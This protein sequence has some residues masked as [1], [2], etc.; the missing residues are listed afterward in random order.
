MSGREKQATKFAVIDIVLNTISAIITLEF[1]GMVYMVAVKVLITIGTQFWGIQR[2]TNSTLHLSMYEYFKKCIL[3]TGLV[4]ILP[5]ISLF[6]FVANQELESWTLSK[7]VI[8]SSTYGITFIL[9]GYIFVLL[10]EDRKLLR[11]VS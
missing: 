7:F 8:A 11:E 10:P 4:S 5:A 9:L 6:Y 1:L 2:L 3:R